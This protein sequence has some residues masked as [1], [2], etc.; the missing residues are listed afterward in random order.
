MA[1][2]VTTG[3]ITVSR[4]VTRPSVSTWLV[5]CNAICMVGPAFPT[6]TRLIQPTRCS[7]VQT[8]I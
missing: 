7:Q 1:A 6:Q 2:M 4:M 8:T 5:C 3:V